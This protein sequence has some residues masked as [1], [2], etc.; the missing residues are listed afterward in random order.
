MPFSTAFLSLSL[1]LSLSFSPFLYASLFFFDSWF[2]G[3]DLVVVVLKGKA[4]L[5]AF[6]VDDVDKA[7]GARGGVGGLEH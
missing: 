6:K 7:G 4:D 3:V 2:R 1:S 5:S